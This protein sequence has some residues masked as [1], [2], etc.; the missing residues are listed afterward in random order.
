MLRQSIISYADPA[1]GAMQPAVDKKD[2]SDSTAIVQLRDQLQRLK[3]EM[4]SSARAQEEEQSRLQ[5]VCSWGW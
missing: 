4:V 5:E 1:A 3:A 2:A